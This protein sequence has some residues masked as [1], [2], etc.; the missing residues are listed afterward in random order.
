MQLKRTPPARVA[1]SLPDCQALKQSVTIRRLP[2]QGSH[3]VDRLT[4][5]NNPPPTIQSAS[6]ASL[7]TFRNNGNHIGEPL[8][9][10]RLYYKK[11]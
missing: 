3:T 2:W 6:L 8:Y 1:H 11:S 5:R 9:E 7:V 10:H 4:F